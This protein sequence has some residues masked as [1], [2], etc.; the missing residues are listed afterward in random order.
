MVSIF[1]CVFLAIWTSSFEKALFSSFAYFFIGS[2][3][4]GEFSF[5]ELPVYLVIS[6]LS[7]VQL[8]KIF[9][10]LCA[11][12]LQLRNHFFCCEEAF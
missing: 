10:P 9:L 6:P 7:D 4:L 1:S 12:P 11:W 5:F 2:L 3:I 8:A